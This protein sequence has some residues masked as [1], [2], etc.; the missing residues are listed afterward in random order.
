LRR[1]YG[2]DPHDELIDEPALYINRLDQRIETGWM[3]RRRSGAQ[4]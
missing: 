4:N 2:I 3:L 1:G